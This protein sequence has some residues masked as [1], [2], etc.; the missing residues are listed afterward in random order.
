MRNDQRQFFIYD[1]EIA[2][3]NE[4]ASLPT[5][6]DVLPIWDAMA[7]A[8]RHLPVRARTAT[9]LLGEVAI[10]AAQEFATLLVRLSDTLA[11]NSVYSDPASRDF[12][13][14]VKTGRQGAD[15]GCHVLISMRPEQGIPNTYTCAIEKM[16]GLSAELVRRLLSKLLNYKYHDDPSFY[17]YPD[18][19]GGLKRDGTPRI[20]RCCP[21]IALRARPSS[22]FINDINN[23]HLTGVSLIKT[24]VAT[25]IA[26]AAYL[27]RQKSELTLGIDRQHLPQANMW[28]AL[29]DAF[30]RHAPQYGAAKVAYRLPGSTRTVTVELDAATGEPLNDLYVQSYQVTRVF[31]LLAQSTER[32]VPHLRDAA[33]PEFLAN[34]TI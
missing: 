6:V 34:R 29:V 11:P 30:R 22:T 2:A 27:T 26:G 13:E 5:M 20:R 32:I 14:H 4:D 16:P 18:P 7:R 24:E 19:A 3:Q 33:I 23:G 1:L 9:L 15:V 31:P 12:Q 21:Y 28:D 10:D 25:P 17:T 8:D